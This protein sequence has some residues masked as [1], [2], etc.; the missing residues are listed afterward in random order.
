MQI[1]CLKRGK[2]V[3][4][5]ILEK[6]VWKCLHI[7]ICRNV[8]K[9]MVKRNEINL[10]KFPKYMLDMSE[11]VALGNMAFSLLSYG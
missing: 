2:G 8:V 10:I 7:S 3:C 9:F 11:M 1:F 4:N 5:L 6:H